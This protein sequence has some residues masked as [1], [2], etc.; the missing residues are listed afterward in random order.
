MSACVH[1]CCLLEI[2]HTVFSLFMMRALKL[3]LS[4]QSY[5]ISIARWGMH[6]S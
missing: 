3:R 4:R 5:R 6:Q 1:H 2:E